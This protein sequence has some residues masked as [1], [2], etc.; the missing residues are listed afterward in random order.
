MT[1]L[2]KPVS[3]THDPVD[4]SILNI[5]NRLEEVREQ[6]LRRMAIDAEDI[7]HKQALRAAYHEEQA[8]L[9][10]DSL[11][12]GLLPGSGVKP[13]LK[14]IS[15][16]FVQK[17]KPV[18]KNFREVGKAARTAATAF[19]ATGEKIGRVK[20]EYVPQPH[21]THRPFKTPEMQL[22]REQLQAAQR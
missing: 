19:K 12:M 16:H 10:Q 3:V 21:L 17:M 15:K 5:T 8:K 6:E 9:Y 14:E 22:L 18:E 11:N 2:N 1:D 13:N 7:E 4:G 20:K